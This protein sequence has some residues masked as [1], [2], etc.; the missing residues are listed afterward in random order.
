MNDDRYT[1]YECHVDL[2]LPGYEDMDDDDEETGIAL[3]Y[4]VTLIKGTND[5]WPSAGTGKKT[6]PCASSGSTSFTTNT[7][8][9]LE[10]TALA[11]STS[12]AD[13]PSQPPASFASWLMQ[14]LSQTC[15]ED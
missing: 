14:E 9:V 5:V 2:N 6:T 15:P 3:P 13:T 7:S 1:L 12:S 8:R 10:L 4:V 11:F